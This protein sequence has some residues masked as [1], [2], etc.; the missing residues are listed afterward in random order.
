ML[1][2]LFVESHLRELIEQ[3]FE[4]ATAGYGIPSGV[5]AIRRRFDL[6]AEALCLAAEAG[7]A[8]RYVGICSM[9]SRR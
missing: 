3:G 9:P 1:A 8:L 5:M 7:L 6:R 2:N 4:V